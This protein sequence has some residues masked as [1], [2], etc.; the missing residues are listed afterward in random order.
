MQTQRRAELENIAAAAAEYAVTQRQAKCE[1]DA[2]PTG[3]LDTSPERAQTQ[4]RAELENNG[5]KTEEGDTVPVHDEG[6]E[7]DATAAAQR[8]YTERKAK[9]E[10]TP[11]EQLSHGDAAAVAERAYHRRKAEVEQQ[12]ADQLSHEELLGGAGG[13]KIYTERGYRTWKVVFSA[14]FFPRCLFCSY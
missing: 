9:V 3:D 2:V 6:D 4:R 5:D 13:L 7:G 10:R 12:P 1:G 11:M 14:L 8:A